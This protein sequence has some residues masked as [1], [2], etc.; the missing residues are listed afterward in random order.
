MAEELS[1]GQRLAL[2]QRQVS[3]LHYRP[4][5]TAVDSYIKP[6]AKLWDLVCCWKGAGLSL[7]YAIKL[8]N[9]RGYPLFSFVDQLIWQ[10]S[11][12]S[13]QIKL[14]FKFLIGGVHGWMPDDCY[15]YLDEIAGSPFKARDPVATSEAT[16]LRSYFALNKKVSVAGGKDCRS[17]DWCNAQLE[18]PGSALTTFPGSPF[19][20]LVHGANHISQ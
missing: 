2:Q 11:I 16:L 20:N 10:P 17:L 14:A 3:R 5:C 7:F 9:T 12:V 8:W 13:D 19:L 4:W 6:L 1:L 18:F 15:F